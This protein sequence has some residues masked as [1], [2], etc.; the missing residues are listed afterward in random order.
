MCQD[1]FE[2]DV[3][4]INQDT[5][6]AFHHN[7]RVVYMSSSFLLM[8][9]VSRNLSQAEKERIGKYTSYIMYWLDFTFQL[10]Q[11]LVQSHVKVVSLVLALE[12]IGPKS[13]LVSELV[14]QMA[15]EL[16]NNHLIPVH[17]FSGKNHNKQILN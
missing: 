16:I 10:A 9:F 11:I 14:T 7:T 12:A 15:V 2:Q 1:R 3:G 5:G 6:F 4:S 13:E 17:S 8:A